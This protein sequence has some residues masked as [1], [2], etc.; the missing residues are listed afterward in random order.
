MLWLLLVGICAADPEVSATLTADG[1]YTIRV[2]PDTP[3]TAGELRV[4]GGET[5]DL[6]PSE[7]KQ[8]VTVSGWTDSQQALQVTLSVAGTDGKGRTW[9][10]EVEPFRTPAKGPVMTP[11]RRP[12]PFSGAR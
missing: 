8:I 7:A 2:I 6:G 11:K 10:M 9:I 4:L 12:W 5:A 1:Q 3:W